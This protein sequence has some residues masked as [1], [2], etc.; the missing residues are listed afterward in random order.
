MDASDAHFAKTGQRIPLAHN[1]LAWHAKGGITLTQ[2]NQKKGWLTPKEEENIV[3]FAI[4]IA[5]WG[6]PLSP[7]QVE[8]TL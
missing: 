2:S 7:R 4:E 8:G 5:Q 1:T 3:N 6:F